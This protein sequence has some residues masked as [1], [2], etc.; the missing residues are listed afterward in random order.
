MAPAFRPAVIGAASKNA[1]Q[2][3]FK[4]TE[5]DNSKTVAL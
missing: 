4:C 1:K 2:A 5:Y 3:T